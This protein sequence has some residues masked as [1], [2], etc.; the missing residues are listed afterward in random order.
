LKRPIRMG[1]VQDLFESKASPEGRELHHS[2]LKKLD[3][4]RFAVEEAR[5]PAIFEIQSSILMTIFRAEVASAHSAFYHEHSTLYSDK[6]RALV[7]TGMLLD[8]RSYLRA[9]RLRKI[10]QHDLARLFQTFDVL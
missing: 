4:Q 7:E 3:R 2:F 9:L 10:Y 8:A 6:L 5:L 1:V